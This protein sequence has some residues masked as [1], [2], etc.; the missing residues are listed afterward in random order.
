MEAVRLLQTESSFNPQFIFIDI[1]MPH[2]S[3]LECLSIIRSMERLSE[4]SIVMCSTSS[5]AGNID[6][7]RKLGAR[8]YFV[9]QGSL[10]VISETLAKLFH[11][12]AL[13]FV[14]PEGPNLT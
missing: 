8:H 13:P 14:I 12:E 6:A 10:K 2:V 5:R 9:K 11:K 7:A 3:G 4:T 1:D